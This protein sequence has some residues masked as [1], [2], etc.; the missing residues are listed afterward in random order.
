MIKARPQ[1]TVRHPIVRSARTIFEQIGPS[2]TGYNR[3]DAIVMVISVKKGRDYNDI[4]AWSLSGPTLG[5]LRHIRNSFDEEYP[6]GGHDD[7]RF[8]FANHNPEG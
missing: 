5:D 8:W 1:P 2:I 4:A 7:D 6:A 3:F